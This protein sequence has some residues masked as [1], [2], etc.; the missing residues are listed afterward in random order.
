[1]KLPPVI[2]TFHCCGF[3]LSLWGNEICNSFWFWTKFWC[4]TYLPSC[5]DFIFVRI[6]VKTNHF[7]SMGTITHFPRDHVL[8][9]VITNLLLTFCSSTGSS[10]KSPQEPWIK[11]RYT[12]PVNTSWDPM[13]SSK[14]LTQTHILWHWAM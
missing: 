10:D 9:L 3:F 7:H 6:K 8:I 14:P 1:M 2:R 4:K 5:F 13:W 12:P 11:L